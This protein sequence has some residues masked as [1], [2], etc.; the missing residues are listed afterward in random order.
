[1]SLG[2]ASPSTLSTPIRS[3]TAPSASLRCLSSFPGERDSARARQDRWCLP[4]QITFEGSCLC[5]GLQPYSAH[6]SISMA[7]RWPALCKPKGMQCPQAAEPRPPSETGC[8]VGWLE[9]KPPCRLANGPVRDFLKNN[10]G[11]EQDPIAGVAST[12]HS[13]NCPRVERLFPDP[14][15]SPTAWTRRTDSASKGPVSRETGPLETRFYDCLACPVC[16]QGSVRDPECPTTRKQHSSAVAC[17]RL[18]PPLAWLGWHNTHPANNET[19]FYAA[20]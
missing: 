6:S 2:L 13:Q 9:R 11:K 4:R 3:N 12:F 1:M 14:V 16:V 7:S 17:R 5:L 8:C 15:R 10:H 19:S 18:G 20:R